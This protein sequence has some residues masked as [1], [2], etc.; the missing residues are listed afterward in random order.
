[1]NTK[2]I[3]D[4]EKVKNFVGDFTKYFE[5]Q[6]KRYKKDAEKIKA[7]RECFWKKYSEIFRD[8]SE[9]EVEMDT[10]MKTKPPMDRKEKLRKSEK[11]LLSN[12]TKEKFTDYLDVSNDKNLCPAQKI[13]NLRKGVDDSTRRKIYYASLQGK[14]LEECFQKLKKVLKKLW[15]KRKLQDGGHYFCENYTNLFSTTVNF[16]FALFLYVFF[17]VTSR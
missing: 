14:V 6:A 13:I 8:S 16:N 1:M 2:R 17:T 11:K 5:D 3:L 4:E 12:K 10:T 7:R 9:N 15:R